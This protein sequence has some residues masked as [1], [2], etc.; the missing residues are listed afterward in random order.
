MRQAL[1]A[2]RRVHRADRETAVAQAEVDDSVADCRR[3]FA[4]RVLL[5]V[6]VPEDSWLTIGGRF[7]SQAIK[8]VGTGSDEDFSV[9]DG[10]GRF[11]VTLRP[12]LPFLV[13]EQVQASHSC[14]LHL[15]QSF[16][17]DDTAIGDDWR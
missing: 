3:R 9:G 6:Q 2:G 11:D 7:E 17:A 12:K 5:T 13:S 10:G 8:A 15:M 16:A 1:R 4:V 14:I